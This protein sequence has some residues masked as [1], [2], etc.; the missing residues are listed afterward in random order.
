MYLAFYS[1]MTSAPL[2]VYGVVNLLLALNGFF[3]MLALF[4]VW[5]ND[6]H[7]PLAD[8]LL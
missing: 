2:I 5:Y 3:G 8:P 7:H 6:I 1:Y 4:R